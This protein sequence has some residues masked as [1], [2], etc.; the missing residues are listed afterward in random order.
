MNGKAAAIILTCALIVT[1]VLVI[2]LAVFHAD[3]A[4][5]LFRIAISLVVLYAL[6]KRV[7]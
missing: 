6:Y 2:F 5:N 7:L 4:I 3:A 1:L